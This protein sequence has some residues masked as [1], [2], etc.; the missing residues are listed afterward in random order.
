MKESAIARDKLVAELKT[1]IA[2]MEALLAATADESGEKWQTLRTHVEDILEQAKLR[3]EKLE[4]AVLENVKST[5]K[6]AD[7]YIHENPWPA[8]GIGAG[9]GLIAGLILARK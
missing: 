6:A 7:G 3:M 1:V 8:V 4:D 5:A 2:E 9:L